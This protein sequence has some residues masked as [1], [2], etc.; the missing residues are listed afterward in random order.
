MHIHHGLSAT[1]TLGGALSAVC[2]QWQVP[3]VVSA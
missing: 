1:Q 2:Q 3:L